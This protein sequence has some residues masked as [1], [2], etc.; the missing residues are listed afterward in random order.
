MRVKRSR[1]R[2]GA[3]V[4]GEQDDFAAVQ[5]GLFDQCGGRIDRARSRV[6]S[7]RH[8][9]RIERIDQIAHRA[10]VVGQRRRDERIRSVTD[11]GGLVVATARQDVVEF[12]ARAGQPIRFFILCE[13]AWRE[14][15]REY[16]RA[17]VAVQRHRFALPGGTGQD[18]TGQ[19]PQQDRER[20]AGAGRTAIDALDQMRQQMR[21]D[22]RT[23]R[24]RV[25]ATMAPS[26]PEQRHREQQQQ[27]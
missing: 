17:L 25:A 9:A 12:E 20:D 26:K 15:E 3:R 13:H 21:I 6:A 5:A 23:P 22:R 11:Q 24:A 4:V 7:D 18:D 8:R 2:V 10:D 16:T 19:C 14:L 1:G 27:S